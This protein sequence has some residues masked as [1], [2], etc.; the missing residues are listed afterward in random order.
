[1]L[2][3]PTR[4]GQPS[5][6]QKQEGVGGS[7][8]LAVPPLRGLTQGGGAAPGGGPVRCGRSLRALPVFPEQGPQGQA[9][10]L[11][12]P[13]DPGFAG[14]RSRPGCRASL[15]EMSGNADARC[16]GWAGRG[17]WGRRREAREGMQIGVM[18]YASARASH[19]FGAEWKRVRPRRGRG[20]QD[21]DARGGRIRIPEPAQHPGASA[22]PGY[23]AT[24]AIWR[25]GGRFRVSWRDLAS[26]QESREKSR[27]P[28]RV[29]R[30]DALPPPTPH[31]LLMD[32]CTLA[33]HWPR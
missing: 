27:R 24:G 11:R 7:A 10:P 17:R 3:S 22:A 19:T 14:R 18:N 12:G 5:G 4:P 8:L 20:R 6:L 31:M 23:R 16:S 25:G 33:H 32:P 13:A 15:R 30:P 1:M 21:K 2:P 9:P 29:V 26:W 28:L